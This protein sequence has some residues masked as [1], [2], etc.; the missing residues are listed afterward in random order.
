MVESAELPESPQVGGE[1][2]AEVQPPQGTDDHSYGHPPSSGERGIPVNLAV[3]LAPQ[4][5]NV[6]KDMRDTLS[7]LT[8]CIKTNLPLIY[9][10]NECN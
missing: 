9:Q 7:D 4:M 1:E 2:I 8:E 3:T 10:F 6:Q 5:L